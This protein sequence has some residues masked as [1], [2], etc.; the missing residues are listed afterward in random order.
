MS[1]DS[2]NKETTHSLDRGHFRTRRSKRSTLLAGPQTSLGESV[3]TKHVLF[4]E[5]TTSRDECVN[6]RSE[7]FLLGH[8]LPRTSPSTRCKSVAGARTSLD[9]SSQHHKL[10]CWATDAT[11]IPPPVAMLADDDAGADAADTVVTAFVTT[12][13]PDMNGSVA[14]IAKDCAPPMPLRDERMSS[15]VKLFG[16]Q[17]KGPVKPLD[18][19]CDRIIV[20]R[21]ERM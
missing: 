5:K 2:M 16:T 20:L 13:A 4:V 3:N 18:N 1:S 7:S 17:P 11:D 19:A 8:G 9:E 12:V 10:C 14:A 15:D 6:K 21:D